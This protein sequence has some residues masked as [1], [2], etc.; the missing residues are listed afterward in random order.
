[1]ENN[2]NTDAAL[3]S[4]NAARAS[5]GLPPVAEIPKPGPQ[6]TVVPS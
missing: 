4:F 6:L 1:M 5:H 2:Q 3:A